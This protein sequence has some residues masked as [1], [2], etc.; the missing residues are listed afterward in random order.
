MYQ[1]TIDTVGCAKFV[2]VPL[3]IVQPDFN[4]KPSWKADR[5]AYLIQ[6]ADFD[7]STLDIGP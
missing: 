6:T 3:V 1:I 4:K 7:I 5:S 2:F